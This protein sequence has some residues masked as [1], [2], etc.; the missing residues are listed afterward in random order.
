MKKFVIFII[1]GCLISVSVYA[2]HIVVYNNTDT[3]FKV[4][5]G[6]H[7]DLGL[8]Y[9]IKP[10]YYVQMEVYGDHHGRAD[11]QAIDSYGN[12]LK[13]KGFDFHHGNESYDW[14]V[15]Y[16]ESSDG[17]YNNH[18]ADNGYNNNYNN[19]VSCESINS[20]KQTCS[21]P[22]DAHVSFYSQLSRASCNYNWGFNANYIWVDHGCRAEFTVSRGH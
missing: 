20:R 2:G 16:H 17:G 9:S 18:H 4:S 3:S 12:V 8:S 6:H 13:T 19:I 15:Y 1:L 7:G 5:C 21:I 22:H 10:R 11:C 14:K